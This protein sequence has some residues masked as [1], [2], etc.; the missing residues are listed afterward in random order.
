L[1]QVN[2]IPVVEVGELTESDD[3]VICKGENY[4]MD[5]SMHT[6]VVVLKEYKVLLRKEKFISD[7][8]TVESQSDRLRLPC[9]E[10]DRG[11]STGDGT[12]LWTLPENTCGLQLVRQFNP[13]PVMKSYLLDHDLRI[14]VN[15]T[16]I[17]RLEGCDAEL[18]KTNYPDLFLLSIDQ[19][20]EMNELEPGDLDIALEGKVAR[21]YMT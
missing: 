17:T 20:L 9:P 16:G 4:H 1:D 14:L 15:T 12:F 7:G 21:D 3:K 11:C 2:A 19:S 18:V 5:N 6:N 8:K 13:V 10:A